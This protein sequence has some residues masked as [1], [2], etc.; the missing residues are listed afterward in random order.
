MEEG[1]Q[2]WSVD[3]VLLAPLYC[4]GSCQQADSQFNLS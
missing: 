3:S 1:G 4:F 2:V